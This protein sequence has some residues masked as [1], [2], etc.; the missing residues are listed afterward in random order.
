MVYHAK[1]SP[2]GEPA[3]V[4]PLVDMVALTPFSPP[5][6][7]YNTPDTHMRHDVTRRQWWKRFGL[8]GLITML[9]G[10]A[11]ILVI[12]LFLGFVWREALVAIEGQEPSWLWYCIITNGWITK[13]VT[14]STTVLRTLIATQAGLFT[15][16]LS[17]LFLEQVGVP[18]IDVPFFSLARA[19]QSSPH[20]LF[21]S[22]TV[23]HL[24]N[25]KTRGACALAVI[26]VITTLRNSC[27]LS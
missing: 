15:S 5:N 25:Y 4:L 7:G 20:N 2:N 23:P 11:A 19:F 27:R 17:A 22:Q 24:R 10:S 3:D 6:D 16:M 8:F 9:A 26:E 18:I 13:I 21:L 14:V 12:L 1:R